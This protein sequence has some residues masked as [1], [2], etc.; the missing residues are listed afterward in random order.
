MTVEEKRPGGEHT[1]KLSAGLFCFMAA[2][3]G[4]FQAFKLHF[5][6]SGVQ[7]VLFQQILM[8]SPF[9]DPLAVDDDDLIGIPDGG[10]PVGD[11]DGGA[12]PG[13][14]L[15]AFLDVALT[16]IVQGAGGLIQDQDRRIFK[17]YPGNGDPLLLA[18]GK[19]CASL[20]HK[21]VVAVGKLHDEIMDAGLFGGGNDLL[22][23]GPW[24]SVGDV[25]TDGA[26]E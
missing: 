20:A 11:G 21:G 23:G 4:L 13:E 5:I 14:L 6:I 18:A 26:A 12:V 22:V 1:V 9:S 15:Q 24:F 10:K 19:P 2:H 25:F 17:E 7:A 3:L 16:F 8:G